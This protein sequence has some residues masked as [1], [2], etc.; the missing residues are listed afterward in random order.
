MSG[1]SKWHS[2]KHKKAATDSK[3]GRIFTRLIKEMTVA[4]R[5]GGGD[6]DANPR[7][8]LL[9][10]NAKSANMPAEN[11]KRA[12]MRGTG[13][14]PG[15]S[16]EEVTYEGY[17]PGGIALILESVTDNKNRTVAEVRHLLDK[18]N[19]KFGAANSVAWMFHRKG[20]IHVSKA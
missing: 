16:Y 18:Y 4:A 14:L 8:R 17:G 20:I 11:I 10:N 12:I 5:S 19:G 6:L 7:L 3:R 9:V 1:H 13:E 2:I 15:I